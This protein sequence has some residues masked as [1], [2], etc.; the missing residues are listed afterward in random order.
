MHSLSARIW[1]LTAFSKTDCILCK[2]SVAAQIERVPRE[3]HVTARRA[4]ADLLSLTFVSFT[5]FHF[6]A[7]IVSDCKKCQQV[8][9]MSENPLN[10][11][12]SINASTTKRINVRESC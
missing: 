10:V 3:Y 1:N 5:F 7:Q 8:L 4:L 2:P 6:L 9:Q 12:K 11:S